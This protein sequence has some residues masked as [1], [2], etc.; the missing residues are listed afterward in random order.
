MFVLGVFLDRIF[1]HSDWIRKVTPYLSVFSPN[2]GKCGPEKSPNRY[3]FHACL[4]D[5]IKTSKQ[6][7]YC[8]MTNKI[9]K[10][11]KSSKVYWSL[12]KSILN[13]KKIIFIPPLF[14]DNCFITDFKENTFWHFNS[15]W[16]NNN[17]KQKALVNYWPI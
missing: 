14:H 12:L 7:C 4:M 17:P 1:P 6:K 10:I 8:R 11:Q 16:L 15:Y 5:L 9:I 13:N 3:T 2:A